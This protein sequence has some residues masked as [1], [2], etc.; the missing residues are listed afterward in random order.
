[1]KS[2]RTQR[3]EERARKELVEELLISYEESAEDPTNNPEPETV[4]LP[5]CE[6][7]VLLQKLQKENAELLQR[8]HRLEATNTNLTMALR[9]KATIDEAKFVEDIKGLLKDFLS[10]AQIDLALKLR[11]RVQWS[12]EDISRAFGIRY[13]S[14]G[15]YN[16]IRNTIKY[17]LPSLTTL[18]KWSR[19]LEIKPG[20]FDKVLK[21]MQVCGQSMTP[22]ERV[23][24]LEFDEMGVAKDV[25]KGV[26]LAPRRTMQM[27]MV[28]GLF[29][30]WKQAI[31]AQIDVPVTAHLVKEAARKLHDCGFPVAAMVSDCG[32]S[33]ERV[34]NELGIQWV[35]DDSIG[36]C[37]LEGTSFDHPVEGEIFVF[38]DAPHLLKLLSNRLLSEGFVLQSGG[39][40]SSRPL[41]QLLGLSQSEVSAIFNLPADRQLFSNSRSL[42]NIPADAEIFS[43]PNVVR[44][45]REHLP[46]DEEANSLADVLQIINK[47]FDVLD[48]SSVMESNRP[49]GLAIAA[50]TEALDE[51]N[52][53]M[54]TMRCR[55]K[56]SLQDFQ[57]AIIMSNRSLLLLFEKMKETFQV[58]HLLTKHLSLDCLESYFG[59]IRG[60]DGDLA[61]K[62]LCPLKALHRIKMISLGK[63]MEA[64]DSGSRFLLAD[65]LTKVNL[66]G[67]EGD[68]D[69]E[70][71]E[72]SDALPS[73]PGSSA[74][75]GVMYETIE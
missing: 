10:P 62:W 39:S 54:F 74:D 30:N 45:L 72:D 51:M 5:C 69:V 58:P 73:L 8:N 59:N 50:Q 43:N 46:M 71:M 36:I 3:E 24:V 63:Q 29:S 67:K 15:A 32:E 26:T 48:S 7:S 37:S 65:C 13:F 68:A 12:E 40:V 47:W 27:M 9:G 20:L 21:I 17:P 23:C 1:M 33:N 49:F 22:T 38:S 53:L 70:D 35:V 11:K 14:K 42:Q 18:M 41:K 52:N 75:P 56:D 55:E 66:L 64:N 60:H 2:E 16:Y 28:R 44:A 61:D 19:R 57:R 6:S 25:E 4:F 31:Y 34:W